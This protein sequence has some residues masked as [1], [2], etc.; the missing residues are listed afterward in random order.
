MVLFPLAAEIL[1]VLLYTEIA[2][3]PHFDFVV[4]FTDDGRE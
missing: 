1:K 4:S 3:T 2:A